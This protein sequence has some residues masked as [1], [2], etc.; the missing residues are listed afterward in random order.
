MDLGLNSKV[1]IITGGTKGIGLYTARQLLLEGALVTICG[2]NEGALTEANTFLKAETGKEALAIVADVTNKEQCENLIDQTAKTYGNIDILINNA[3]STSAH[4]FENVS[5]EMWK[6]D[7]DLK[8]F[9]AIHCSQAV[10]PYLKK[11]GGAIVNVT[12]VIAKT[13]SA[14][15]LPTTVSRSS[16][17]ALTKAMSKDLGKYNIR[18]NTVCIGLIRSNQIEQMWQKDNPQNTWEEFSTEMAKRIP[19][20]L[21]RIGYTQEAANVITFLVSDAASYVT[22][23][24]VNIDGGLGGTL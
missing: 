3:G 4:S 17:M 19:I 13:P 1:A 9:G 23:T 15:S 22:G 2:R 5:I 6:Q 24:S 10:L 7:L 18:V 11:N 20:P 14:N 12:A 8:L 21:G 16:G